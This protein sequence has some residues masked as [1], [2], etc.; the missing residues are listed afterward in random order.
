M[1]YSPDGALLALGLQSGQVIVLDADKYTTIATR[2]DRA[3]AI[4][5]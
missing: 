4:S 3:A 2:K 5:V 1:A